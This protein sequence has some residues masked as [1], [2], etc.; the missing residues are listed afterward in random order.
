MGAALGYRIRNHVLSI[1][2]ILI[3]F[4]IH[5]SEFDIQI[6][7]ILIFNINVERQSQ[8]FLFSILNTEHRMSNNEYT[9]ISKACL[10]SLDERV[11]R[12]KG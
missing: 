7:S 2:V 11:R 8:I 4:D 3:V 6:L 12:G 9:D 5:Y 1:G 10:V